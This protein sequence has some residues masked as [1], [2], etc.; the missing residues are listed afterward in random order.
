MR[1]SSLKL[2]HFWS[3]GQDEGVFSHGPQGEGDGAAVV[4]LQPLGSDNSTLRRDES[5]TVF[6]NE[7]RFNLKKKKAS[8]RDTVVVHRGEAKTSGSRH[9][10]WLAF[11]VGSAYTGLFRR[12]TV[13]GEGRP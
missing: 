2:S 5:R 3:G 12:A 1:D 6:Q 7:N 4:A 13:P 10:L 8:D 9:R 11:S